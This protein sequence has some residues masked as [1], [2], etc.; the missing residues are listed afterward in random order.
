LASKK[1]DPIVEE[2]KKKVK[3]EVRFDS[4]TRALYSTTASICQTEPI[5]LVIPKDGDDV[6]AVTGASCRQQIENTVL[7]GK[8]A[9]LLGSSPRH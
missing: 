5:G 6:I 4:Y 8:L 7:E 3:S 2:L 1:K 9:M